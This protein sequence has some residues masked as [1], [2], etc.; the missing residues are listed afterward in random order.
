MEFK[1]NV[2][3]DFVLKNVGYEKLYI[4]IDKVSVWEKWID[5]IKYFGLEGI[6]LF[7]FKVFVE[8]FVIYYFL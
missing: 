8:D 4:F 6:Y 3:I 5:N 2:V 1:Y 7:V